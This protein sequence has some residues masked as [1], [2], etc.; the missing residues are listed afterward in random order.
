MIERFELQSGSASSS[1]DP[2]STQKPPARQRRPRL[3]VWAI[4]GVLVAV[5]LAALAYGAL[6]VL[7]PRDA[8]AVFELPYVQDFT[9]IDPREWPMVDG[10]WSI[11]NE[12]LVQVANLTRPAAIYVPQQVAADQPYHFSTYIVVAKSTRRAGINFNAQYPNMSEQQHQVYIA[13]QL[14]DLS[15][16]AD[17][18]R[19]ASMEME[20]VAGYTDAQ[21]E[22]VKQVAVPFGPDTGEYR[23]DLY[24]L[25]NT[26]TVQLNGQTLIERRPL[27]F[28]NGLV[29]YYT[30]GPARF[31]SL[32]LTTATTEEPGEQ[33]YMSDFDQQPGGAGWVPFAGEWE[34]SEGELVQANPAAQDAGIGYEG[35]SFEDYV[36]QANFRHL[37]GVGG[38]LLFNMLSPYQ[39]SSAQVV[40]FSDQSDSLFWGYFDDEGQFTRQGFANVE[41]AGMELRQLRVFVGAGSYDVYLDQKLM[42]RAVPVHLTSD[43]TLGEGTG[44]EGAAEEATVGRVG[45]HIGLITSRSSVAYTLVEVFPLLN[46]TPLTNVNASDPATPEPVASAPAASGDQTP[47]PATPEPAQSASASPSP[48]PSASPTSSAPE[49]QESNI[50][51]LLPTVTP[52]PVR[53]G[54]GTPIVTATVRVTDTLLPDDSDLIL[55]GQSALWEGDFRG[56]LSSAGWR[57]LAGAW[58]ISNGSLVQDDSL[59]F[60]LAVAYTRNAF[61]DY[62]YTATFAHR[63]G[64][65]AGILFNM[66]YRDQLNGA[67]MVR[68]SDRRPGGIFWGYFDEQ[69]RFVGQGYANVSPPGDARHTLHVVSGVTTYDVYLDDFLLAADLPLMQNYGYVGLITVQSS[70][71]FIRTQ[72]DGRG[73]TVPSAAQ[74]PVTSLP[75]AAAGVYSGTLGFP[76]EGILSGRWEVEAGVFRQTS[77]DVADYI[78]TTG[79][80]AANYSIDA[81]IFLPDMRDV[82]GG[83]MLQMPERRSKVG[84]TVV[85]LI[86]GGQ[87]IFWGV[88]DEAGIFRGR[89]SVDLPLRPEGETGYR[90]HVDGKGD[91][92]DIF[93]DDVLIAEA[94]T[95]PRAEG[96]IGLVAFGGPVALGNVQVVVLDE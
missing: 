9:D 25:E 34:I 22:F 3:L 12:M 32:K 63:D 24:V 4:R 72:V 74:T 86:K 57:P 6:R 54:A 33:V 53:S 27:F 76:D 20:L 58:R 51:N 60:D 14:A 35:S 16:L 21:G 56:S 91:R 23:L 47:L 49:E 71:E 88:Y 26:Y 90:L 10:I 70:A 30:L 52:T 18:E 38:G 83:L 94:V 89:G 41:P 5:V 79:L 11:R 31:D 39:A 44:D 62:T 84:A 36:V 81:D 1:D 48:T 43:T 28:K 50:W 15:E 29:G 64:N 65:G 67:H 95:L 78:Y 82:G 75:L 87:G 77:A 68:Y 45:G 42:A 61:Q 46:N 7:G 8:I 19:D 85:R 80:Y 37:T 40:R 93:L 69:G 17:D 66:P 92:L 13:R 96:W 73:A 59:G 55:A 2:S